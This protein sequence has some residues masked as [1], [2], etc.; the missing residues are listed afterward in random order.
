ML[1][2]DRMSKG[3]LIVL[4]AATAHGAAGRRFDPV[5][6]LGSWKDHLYTALNDG[7]SGFRAVVEMDW[8]KEVDLPLDLLVD[9]ERSRNDLF[10]GLPG[11]VLCVYD[12][13][14]FDDHTL[15]RVGHVHPCRLGQ[16]IEPVNVLQ[17]DLLEIRTAGPG[18]LT[19][20]GEVDASNM[21]VV[22]EVV[23][24]AADDEGRLL[25]DMAG[26]VFIDFAGLRAIHELSRRIGRDGGKLILVS[27][28]TI[29]RR[30]V[31]LL[32]AESLTVE[33]GLTGRAGR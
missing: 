22:T 3:E 9:Y 32:G 30:M 19:L 6:R 1:E 5:A 2:A 14:H 23:G 31:E 18:A 27:P 33:E 21:G 15:A 25:I 16:L 7:F 26:I 17:S 4:P 20:I 10:R 28:P 8:L 12:R 13:R 29:A 11:T 24:S